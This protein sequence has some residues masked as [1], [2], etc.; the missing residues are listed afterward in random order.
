MLTVSQTFQSPQ[1]EKLPAQLGGRGIH[2]QDD[3]LKKCGME[4]KKA[5]IT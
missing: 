3:A 5:L 2:Q 4:R 1:G